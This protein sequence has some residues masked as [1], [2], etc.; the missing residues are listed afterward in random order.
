[1]AF[2]EQNADKSRLEVSGANKANQ[3]LHDD[4]SIDDPCIDVNV[5]FPDVDQ[6]KFAVTYHAILHDHAFKTV[7]INKKRFRAICKRANKGCKWTFSHL[8]ARS[9]LD[10]R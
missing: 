1:M 7:I 3:A 8:Q 5:V 9:T 10:A 2:E 4:G 6:C